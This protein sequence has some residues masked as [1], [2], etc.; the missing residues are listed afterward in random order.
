MHPS[1]A[2][3][4]AIRT[5]PRADQAHSKRPTAIGTAGPEQLKPEQLREPGSNPATTAR[6]SIDTHELWR[7]WRGVCYN[8]TTARHSSLPVVAAFNPLELGSADWNCSGN[9]AC[10]S[11]QEA[12][13]S[14]RNATA[15]KICSADAPHFYYL[16]LSE[17][18]IG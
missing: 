8:C 5:H 15:P 14:L 4:S 6:V 13:G 12:G 10:A 2:E 17:E 7:L 3:P 18:G 9:F 1:F 16:V 11:T